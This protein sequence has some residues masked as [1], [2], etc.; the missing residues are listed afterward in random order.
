MMRPDLEYFVQF[1]ASQYNRD[2]E[3]LEKVQQ[4]PT[5]MI[6]GVNHFCEKRLRELGLAKRRLRRISLISVIP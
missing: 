3:I 2:L 6:T 1:W 5:K 4:M